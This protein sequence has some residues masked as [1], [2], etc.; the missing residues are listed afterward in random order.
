M[1]HIWCIMYTKVPQ[2]STQNGVILAPCF[3]TIQC[4]ITVDSTS[5]IHPKLGAYLVHIWM[6]I[7]CTCTLLICHIPLLTQRN[8][9]NMGIYG[10]PYVPSICT[11]LGGICLL[12]Q[13]NQVNTA[14]P[15]MCILY[16]IGWCTVPYCTLYTVYIHYICIYI[17]VYIRTYAYTV[18]VHIQYPPLHMHISVYVQ[19]SLLYMYI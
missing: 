14:Y 1:V 4:R 18:L 11:Y 13:R 17:R 12:T 6:Y 3:S 19:Y 16:H 15:G 8:S 9:P 10:T 5:R 2:N 7:M